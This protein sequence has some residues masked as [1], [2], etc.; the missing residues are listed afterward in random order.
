MKT[1][2]YP[3][4]LQAPAKLWLWGLR[5]FVILAIAVL[6]SVVAAVTAG[7]VLPLALTLCWAFLTIRP[8][9]TTIMDF[10]SWAV[11]YFLTAQQTFWWR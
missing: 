10:L 9:E 11:R 5:D 1:Y 4:N 6:L 3:Q 8:E 2:L 7:T